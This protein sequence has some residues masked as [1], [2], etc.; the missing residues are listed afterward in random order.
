MKAPVH[1]QPIQKH[2]LDIGVFY[3]FDHYI[4]SEIHEGITLTCDNASTFLNL[5]KDHYGSSMP[6]ALI[7]NR[8]HSYAFEPTIHFKFKKLFPNIQGYAIVSYT[9]INNKI[10]QMEQSYLSTPSKLFDTV[11]DA[12]QWAETLIIKD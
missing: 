5:A 6:F 3:F 2:S 1:Y 7:S 11:D 8:I 10:A 12:I 9:P 4:I